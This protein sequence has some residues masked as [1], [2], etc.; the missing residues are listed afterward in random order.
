MLVSAVVEDFLHRLDESL[1]EARI[2]EGPPL[3]GL[4]RLMV[5]MFD[6]G[7]HVLVLYGDPRIVQAVSAR[8]GPDPAADEI[9]RLIRRRGVR[10]LVLLPHAY[11]GSRHRTARPHLRRV[12]PGSRPG[13]PLL[14]GFRNSSCALPHRK[15][16]RPTRP[17]SSKLQHCG[18]SGAR[19]QLA[20]VKPRLELGGPHSGFRP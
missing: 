14:T 16:E 15:D 6:V 12:G 20:G 5:A 4:R 1:K 18:T 2:G 9:G 19:V 11:G 13:V 3:Q 8:G 7:D 17:L 10:S